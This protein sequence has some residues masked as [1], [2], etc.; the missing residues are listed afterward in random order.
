MT[1][2]V[3]DAPS[4]AAPA[5]HPRAQGQRPST[6]RGLPRPVRRLIGPALLLGLWWWASASGHL[7]PT[8]LASPGTVL[9][10]GW[11][12]LQDG[13]LQ[14]ALWVSLQRVLQGLAWGVTAGVALAVL[15]G[16]S[17]WGEDLIDTNLQILRTI[18]I[19]GLLP[20]FII[21]F[22]IDEK[23]KIVMIAVAVMF[24]V[25]VNTFSAIRSVDDRLVEAGS[26]FGLGRV[27]LIRHVLLPAALP[28]FLV[29]L[30]FALVISWLV[31]VFAE[32]LN[33]Q[34]GLG[35]LLNDA[36]AYYETDKIVVVLAVYGLIGLLS[37]SFVRLLERRL[38][39]WR[40]TFSGK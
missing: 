15:A 31:L 10:T 2:V 22:G 12:M 32:T 3:S 17:R 28:G 8:T 9:R 19:I 33:A 21:W 35:S 30:R 40:R 11:H 23:P 7:A 29:G 36:R 20:L 25:Y 5:T 37:D 39:S 1:L 13:T 18:P 4:I 34:K 24:P 14:E 27:G 26:T 38:L 16:L 6:R